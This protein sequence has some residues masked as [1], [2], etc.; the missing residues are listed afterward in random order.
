MASLTLQVGPVTASFSAAD[1]AATTVLLEYAAAIG[2]TGSNQQKAA[3][4]VQSLVAHMVDQARQ[5][6]QRAAIAQ[7]MAAAQPKIESVG[8]E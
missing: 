2:A 8:W 6:K 5:H 1:A 3:A 7:A 4:V